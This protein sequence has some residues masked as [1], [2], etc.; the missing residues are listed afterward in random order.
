MTH[1]TVRTKNSLYNQQGLT[2]RIEECT[3]IPFKIKRRGKHCF[4][5]TFDNPINSK[6]ANKIADNLGLINSY[7]SSAS[8]I[9]SD[10]F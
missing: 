10:D 8:C 2:S 1:L 6:L 4:N 9:I 3:K 7:M 5:V